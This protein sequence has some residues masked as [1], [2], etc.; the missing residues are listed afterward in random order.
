LIDGVIITDRAV[1]GVR[2]QNCRL[3]QN[4]L[5]LLVHTLNFSIKI[6]LFFN[7]LIVWSLVGEQ[8]TNKKQCY[9]K[10]QVKFQS[11]LAL[12]KI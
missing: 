10:Y 9:E 6:A 7:F 11:I 2:A 3:V 12:A 8:L 4:G 5:A 1:G